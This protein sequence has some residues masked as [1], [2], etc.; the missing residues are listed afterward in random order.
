[1]L[2]RCVPSCC[3]GREVSQ[4]WP[5]SASVHC[6]R[7]ALAQSCL[8]SLIG[9]WL[10]TRSGSL[11]TRSRRRRHRGRSKAEPRKDHL[12]LLRADG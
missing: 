12:E 8:A 5:K 6:A 11:C 2:A 7:S 9:G 1:M 4:D 3:A 10:E